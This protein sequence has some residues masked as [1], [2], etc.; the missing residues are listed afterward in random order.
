MHHFIGTGLRLSI[1]AK[2]LSGKKDSGLRN[3]G[4][5]S[6]LGHFHLGG[7]IGLHFICLSVKMQQ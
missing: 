3:A 4:G 1:K 2:G 6:T 5:A 7:K